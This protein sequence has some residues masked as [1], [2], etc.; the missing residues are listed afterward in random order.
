MIDFETAIRDDPD[1]PMF[2]YNLASAYGESVDL[3]LV[4]A[5][6]RAAFQR[7]QNLNQYE[8]MP[9]P[10]KDDSFTRFLWAFRF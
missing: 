9:E 10:A 5:N 6:L 8:T 4:L 1:Y 7:K 2:Y 3:D